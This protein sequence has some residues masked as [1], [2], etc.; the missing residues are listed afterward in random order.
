MKN[1]HLWSLFLLFPYRSRD[2]KVIFLM[3]INYRSGMNH[4]K[5][6]NKAKMEIAMSYNM[7]ANPMTSV[8][9]LTRRVAIKG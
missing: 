5:V 9:P 6:E 8:Q 1:Q 4:Q 2:A 7:P 3:I